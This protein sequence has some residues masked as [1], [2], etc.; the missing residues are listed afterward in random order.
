MNPYKVKYKNNTNV[1]FITVACQELT[2]F[3]N[4]KTFTWNKCSHTNLLRLSGA[5][6]GISLRDTDG[7]WLCQK[8]VFSMVA[9]N[10]QL[11]LPTDAHFAPSKLLPTWPEKQSYSNNML[12]I[13]IPFCGMM[14]QPALHCIV[15]TVTIP[16]GYWFLQLLIL[17]W[18]VFFS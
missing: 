11:F 13:Q 2:P 3:S 12:R 4:F 15:H 7:G 5:V 6:L 9:L 8:G 14:L 18:F 17:F 1:Y 10:L 16:M